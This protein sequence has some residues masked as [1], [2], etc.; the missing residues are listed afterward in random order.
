MSF[1]AL[2]WNCI[3]FRSSGIRIFMALFLFMFY[4]ITMSYRGSLKSV[5]TVTL[6]P[7]PVDNVKD[8]AVKIQEEVRSSIDKD[9]NCWVLSFTFRICWLEAFQI[10]SR[11]LLSKVKIQTWWKLRKDSLPIMILE[12]LFK[13]LQMV[14]LLW[15]KVGDF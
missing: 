1:F 11:K 8:L 4:T 12:L 2:N 13:M 3:F 5:L 14:K 10:L 15:V 7:K 9:L 6:V